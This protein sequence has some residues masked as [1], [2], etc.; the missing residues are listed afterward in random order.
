MDEAIQAHFFVEQGPAL[1]SARQVE[2]MAR[3][4]Q[5]AGLE[6]LAKPVPCLAHIERLG[7]EGLFPVVGQRKARRQ[8]PEKNFLRDL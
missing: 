7:Q 3:P 1:F 8:P 4:L 2:D 5:D 6:Q